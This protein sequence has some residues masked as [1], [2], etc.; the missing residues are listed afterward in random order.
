MISG[1]ASVHGRIMVKG[2]VDFMH[3]IV[4]RQQSRREWYVNVVSISILMVEYFLNL[5][6][7]YVACYII[8][9]VL[10]FTV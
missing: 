8:I 9:I 7:Q 10:L 1:F 2:Q 4:M 3:V 5:L 6:F